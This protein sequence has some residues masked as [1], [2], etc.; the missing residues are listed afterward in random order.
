MGNRRWGRA[1]QRLRR[2]VLDLYGPTCWIDGEPI[3]LDLR[4][5]HPRSYEVDHLLPVSLGGDEFDLA[6]CRPAHRECN[7]RRGNRVNA[8]RRQSRA[9]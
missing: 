3:D 6:N 7:L 4:T 2:D 5:P 9:W 8:R 1:T